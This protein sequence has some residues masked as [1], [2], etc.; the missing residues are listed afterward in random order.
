[1]DKSINLSFTN[2]CWFN[3]KLQKY[4]TY[5]PLRNRRNSLRVQKRDL[6]NVAR[7][8]GTT[9]ASPEPHSSRYRDYYGPL[10]LF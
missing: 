2:S 9:D 4:Y 10:Y 5:H 8:P 1:M 3:R 7:R 6:E